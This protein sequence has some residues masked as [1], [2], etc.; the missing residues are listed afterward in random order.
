MKKE[1]RIIT[2]NSKAKYKP[3]II[4]N[5][6]FSILTF[7]PVVL[8][9]QLKQVSNCFFLMTGVIQFIKV[10]NVAPPISTLFPWL[11][12]LT[13]TLIKEGIDDF[14][15]YKRDKEVNSEKYMKLVNEKFTET[16]CS[17]LRPGDVL[18][19]EKNQRIPADMV[20]LKTNNLDGQVFIRTDQLDGEIDWKLRL[21]L[22]IT[23]ER[24]FDEMT[25]VVLEV[26][27]PNKDIYN[28]FGKIS[29]PKD[30]FAKQGTP[31]MYINTDAKETVGNDASDTKKSTTAQVKTDD[32]GLMPLSVENT[33]W[34]NTI[35]A[36]GQV[37]GMVIYTGGE[38]RAILNTAKPKMK[39]GIFEAELNK[40]AM[41]LGAMSATTSIFFT[42]IRGLTPRVDV[43]FVR[44]LVIF[45][46]V[47][48]I[49]LRTSVELA[50]YFHA[51]MIS[52][53]LDVTVRN[54]N[55]PEE[56]GRISYLLSDKTGTLTRNVM[57]MKKVHL[58]TV[59]YSTENF[60]DLKQELTRSS[61]KRSG[62]K[63]EGKRAFEM[64]KALS[65]CHNVTPVEEEV[66]A[67]KIVSSAP[68]EDHAPKE[69]PSQ[70]EEEHDKA[71]ATAHTVETAQNMTSVWDD[72]E[73]YNTTRGE[74]NV[75]LSTVVNQPKPQ[76]AE[77]GSEVNY[78]AS[79]PDE[80]A[81]IKWCE[82][83][84]MKLVARKSDE[85]RVVMRGEDKAYK[86]LEMFPF[87]SES[88][89]MG[90][91]LKSDEEI[92]FY[93]KGADVVMRDV[94][95]KNDW[96]DEETENMARDG[97]RTL[98]I[99]KKTLSLGEYD[100]FSSALKEAKI[101]GKRE[102]TTEVAKS[103]QKDM[104]LLGITGVEDLLQEDVKITLESLR[105][106]DIKIWMLTGDKVETATSI[107]I[108]S[109]IFSKNSNYLTIKQI[110]TKVG[111]RNVLDDLKRGSFDSIVIDGDSIEVMLS[112]FLVEFIT[113]ASTLKAVVG[114]RCSP[115]QKALLTKHLSAISKKRVAAIGDGGNDVSMIMEADVGFG[116]VGKEGRQAS[117]A[118]DFSLSKFKDVLPLLLWHGRRCYKSTSRLAHLIIHRG[119]V[120]F[121]MQAVFC[122]MFTYPPISI[123]PGVLLMGYSTVYTFGPIF[124]TVLSAD[125][126]RENAMKYPELYKDLVK[127]K[128]LGFQNF[129]KWF[130]FSF[131]QGSFI[132]MGDLYYFEN[133]LSSIIA[134]SFTSLV[135]NEI[136]MVIL[137]VNTFN[138]YIA[139]SITFSVMMYLLSFFILPSGVLVLPPDTKMFVVKVLA[140]N[141][142][143]ITISLLYAIWKRY[144]KPPN[145]SKL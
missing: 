82:T 113:L 41:F 26:E 48:P 118:A 58:G 80:I 96:L 100:K 63:E 91:I 11:L 66:D 8:Y 81:I 35:L 59:C 30:A 10:Y 99:A 25:G 117:L 21:S 120:L 101:S 77:K 94:V 60:D 112:M 133:D 32:A 109:K 23:Q 45:S 79:S 139:I 121:V 38:N 7:V 137:F 39:L 24:K 22:P 55:I 106:A 17:S 131:Y 141:L 123:Y 102:K 28:F 14:K 44:F 92:V 15:R 64:C 56:L 36:T 3:N 78:Q 108:S 18:I 47:I 97:L 46:S 136:L 69:Q 33:M 104:V 116:I 140:I 62:K 16:P 71:D 114:C 42:I 83:I 40:Y 74:M 51:Y 73:D 37:L 145:Y 50:R 127:R 130:F 31:E 111:C 110:K 57:V 29:I 85:I 124:S 126:S 144:L 54:S 34:M 13:L 70:S 65:L 1:L 84:G 9:N 2:H 87:T 88:K 43:P 142:G 105:N 52:K 5:Q 129:F 76:V 143:S 132:M 125:I 128:L 72:S 95:E 19:V 67:N 68:E 134:L 115:T 103:I 107:A 90:I 86:I 20:I 98:V 122:S 53:D 27:D 4:R 135:I 61:E 89:S 93:L 6:R 49:S 75:A 119:T 12:V 138:I